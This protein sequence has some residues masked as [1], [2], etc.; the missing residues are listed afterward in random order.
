MVTIQTAVPVALQGMSENLLEE[1]DEQPKPKKP[2]KPSKFSHFRFV[3]GKR[4]SNFLICFSLAQ[5][6]TIATALFAK[7]SG[8]YWGFF[9]GNFVFCIIGVVINIVLVKKSIDKK[10]FV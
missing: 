10:D 1:E 4:M 6:C 8:I 2:V 9:V 3:S 7:C 5:C